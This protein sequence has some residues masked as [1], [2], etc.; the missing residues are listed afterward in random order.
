MLNLAGFTKKSDLAHAHAIKALNERPARKQQLRW[1][2]QLYALNGTFGERTRAA[3]L[4][5]KDDLPFQYEEH[6]SHAPTRAFLAKQA[7][8]YAEIGDLANY[9]MSRV[10]DSDNLVQVQVT[11]P[12]ADEPE[13]VEARENAIRYLQIQSLHMW[14]TKVLDAGQIDDAAKYESMLALARQFDGN[15]LFQAAS[16]DENLETRRSGVAGI[17]A[18]VLKYREGRAAAEIVW[19]RDAIDRAWAA[20]DIRSQFWSPQSINPW[21]PKIF[22][23]RG[24]GADIS[25]GSAAEEASEQLLAL[26]THPLEMASLA[27]LQETAKLWGQNPKLAWAAMML[28]FE[29]SRLHPP[30]ESEGGRGPGSELHSR[31]RVDEALDAAIDYYRNGSGWAAL[32][33][34][35]HAWVESE[36]ARRRG[37]P[38]EDYD[39]DDMEDDRKGW[40]EP[41]I[42]WYSQY[43]AKVLQNLPLERIL[44]SDVKERFSALWP[45]SCNGRM[46]R[47]RRP[48]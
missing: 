33:T 6:K 25:Y 44:A 28:A 19:A 34:P 46:P 36:A 18:V 39:S 32:P 15:D 26:V 2:A 7:S 35:P 8:E 38:S 29:L 14:A 9:Q 3:I 11:S 21:E 23:A 31:E 42:H 37:S 43:A 12:S 22:V 30:E 24:L 16:E 40:V 48:G 47:M 13:N 41:P 27:A 4:A 45:S 1:L 10:P 20:A 17:A 5:F